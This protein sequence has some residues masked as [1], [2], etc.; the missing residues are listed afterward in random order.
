MK[1]R[2]WKTLQALLC[3][4]VL[5]ALVSGIALLRVAGEVQNTWERAV[6][7]A[8]EVTLPTDAAFDAP[9]ILLQGKPL[10]PVGARR[11]RS[12]DAALPEGAVYDLVQARLPQYAECTLEAERPAAAMQLE[13]QELQWSLEVPQDYAAQLTVTAEDGGIV[14]DGAVDGVYTRSFAANGTDTGALV[15]TREDEHGSVTFSYAFSVTLDVQTAVTLS[16][17]TVS[18]GDVVAVLVSGN[19]F[20]EEM[21]LSTE[22]GLCDFV[23]LDAPGSYGA[24]VPVAYN[25]GV[26][27]WPIEVTVGAQTQTLTVQVENRDFTVQHMTISQEIAD[28]TW[29]SAAASAEY[30]A[31]IY[32]LYELT[33]NDRQW[34]GPF[35]QPVSDYRLTTEYGLWRYTNG[36]YS[37]R[38]SGIDMACP[39]GTPIVAPQGGTVLFAD[40]LQ[41]TG[42]TIVIA[43]GGGVKS[44][45]YHMNSIDVAP[46]DRVTA[47]QKIA[48]VGTTG[49]S[50]GPHLHYEVK[51]GSQ[52]IDPFQLF[53]GSSGL[54]AGQTQGE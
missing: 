45:F 37:E 10:E 47:G 2:L 5:A 40:H 6:Q 22:L 11:I 19:L 26:G 44:M 7:V 4:L 20:G 27:K 28:N 25:R 33:D 38:H 18:Q 14:Y 23:P 49:Y 24:F 52:S 29:N 8:A 35:I 51:I 31:A 9:E 13:T 50:T 34:D 53:D 48:E 15:L 39:L 42:Y 1:K 41:L 30:R 36:V 16:A 54:F 46:G 12:L 32:P 21:T 43:H 3:L 17:Q